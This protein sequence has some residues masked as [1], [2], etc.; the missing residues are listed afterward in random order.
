[1]AEETEPERDALLL[2]LGALV[3]EL[4]RRG[5]R[6]PDLLQ[7]KAAELDSSYE[8]DNSSPL[9]SKSGEEGPQTC[10]NCGEPADQG[11][12]V[13]LHCG[14][15]LELTRESPREPRQKTNPGALAALIAVVAVTAA[16]AG[17]ALSELTN[18]SEPEAEAQRTAQPPETPKTTPE[19][20]AEP[21]PEAEG[22]PQPARRSL[23]LKWPAGLTAH[24]VILVN[25]EDRAS[26][27]RVA[28]EATRSGTETGILR[29]DDYDLGTGLWIVFAGRF[30]SRRGAERQAVNL[31]GRY[32]GAYVQLIEP[33]S[34]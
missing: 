15:R 7:E 13:C 21:A 11:Q 9:R 19:P 22:S 1:M 5:E 30:D 31:S 6:A 24:T 2:E 32:P 26:A 28:I 12:L 29:S 10:P 14:E 17:F 34:Q 3:Y 18:G 27:R 33:T 25:A 4:H 20:A 16:A 23:L 8:R